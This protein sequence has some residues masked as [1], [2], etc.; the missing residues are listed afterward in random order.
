[1]LPS[2]RLFELFYLATPAFVLLDWLVGVPARAAGIPD[3]AWRAAYYGMLMGCWLLCRTV[4]VSAPF[5]GLAESSVNLLL[6]LLSVLLPI[7]SYGEQAM[8]G[9]APGGVLA[10]G[11]LWNVAI[12]GPILVLSIQANERRV[13]GSRFRQGSPGAPV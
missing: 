6:L 13:L 12:S 5:V 9:A 4:P 8:A 10:P 7:W 1:M 2:R 11:A 3:P